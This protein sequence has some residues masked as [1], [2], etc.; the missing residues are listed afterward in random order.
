MGECSLPGQCWVWQSLRLGRNPISHFALPWIFGKFLCF[1]TSLFSSNDIRNLSISLQKC[2]RDPHLHRGLI[3]GVSLSIYG[4]HL[5]PRGA[6]SQE[7]SRVLEKSLTLDT[8][9]KSLKKTNKQTGK[10]H[11]LGFVLQ[12][13]EMKISGAGVVLGSHFSVSLS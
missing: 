7:V 13:G 1:G 4:V 9:P 8:H 6:V 11:H 5:Y 2:I 12:P 3:H 10:Y